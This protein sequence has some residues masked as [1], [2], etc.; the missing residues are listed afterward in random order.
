[1][2]NGVGFRGPLKLLGFSICKWPRKALLEIYFSLNQP[3]SGTEMSQ[4]NNTVY[5]VE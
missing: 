4:L 3:R 2:C 1:M 5:C